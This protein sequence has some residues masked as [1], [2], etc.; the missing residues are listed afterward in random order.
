MAKAKCKCPKPGLT[1]PFYLLTYGDM[2]TLLLTFFVLLFSMSSVQSVKF[3][4]QVG[5]LQ[6]ALGISELYQH[7]PMQRHLPAPSVKQ[8][9]RVVSRSDQSPTAQKPLAES[10]TRSTHNPSKLRDDAR[11]EAIRT[12][13]TRAKLQIQRFE[14]EV[15]ITLPTY[16]L[17]KK[18]S[19]EIDKKS[20]EVRKVEKHYR[21]L[22]KQLAGLVQYDIHFTGH[23]DSLPVVYGAELGQPKDNVE[24]GFLRSV[25]LFQYFFSDELTDRTRI[26]FSSQGDSVPIVPNA[27]LDSERRRNRRVEIHLK[28]I[29]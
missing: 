15:I 24:L 20:P 28:K 16:G 6:G 14:D 4:A 8:S 19:Y 12:L 1:A 17:F 25:A 5:I 27:Q 18:G 7:A 10:G 13:G 26:T 21:E 29:L 2:M 9:T 11:I 3:Q 22:A 23:T